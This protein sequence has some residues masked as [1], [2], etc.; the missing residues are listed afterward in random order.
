[1]KNSKFQKVCILLKKYKIDPDYCSPNLVAEIAY[2]NN[3]Y[4]TSYE[5]VYI[6][7]HYEDTKYT[8]PCN[9]LAKITEQNNNMPKQIRDVLN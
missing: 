9:H 7:D 2:N 3:I 4:L 6:S 5:V 8:D 1:M